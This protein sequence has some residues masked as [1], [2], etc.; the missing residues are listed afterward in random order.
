MQTNKSREKITRIIRKRKIPPY[1]TVKLKSLF[2]IPQSNTI[3]ENPAGR[4]IFSATSGHPH[5][6]INRRRTRRQPGKYYKLQGIVTPNTKSLFSTKGT[7]A[8]R[9]AALARKQ[10]VVSL[11]RKYIKQ[12]ERNVKRKTINWFLGKKPVPKIRVIK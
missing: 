10:K 9:Q 8:E 5:A 3:H 2:D 7:L 1:N 6:F 12:A 11:A 4:S